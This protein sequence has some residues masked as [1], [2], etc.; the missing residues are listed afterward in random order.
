[1]VSFKEFLKKFLTLYYSTNFW[2]GNI[3]D[4]RLSLHQQAHTLNWSPWSGYNYI[5]YKT[6]N[7]M[8]CDEIYEVNISDA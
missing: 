2:I 6:G 4:K 3:F 5:K 1:M 8:H 7:Y